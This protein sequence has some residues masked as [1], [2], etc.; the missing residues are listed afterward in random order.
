MTTKTK[1]LAVAGTVIAKTTQTLMGEVIDTGYHD[2]LTLHFEYNKGDETGLIIQV[3]TALDGDLTD[4]AQWQ[5]WTAAAGA[6]TATVN[7]ITPTDATPHYITFDVR[8]IAFMKF[9]Q[10]GSNNDG[11]PTGTYEASYTL[12]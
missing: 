12:K 10:G 9:T 3:H 6:K 11:T 5:D 4:V 7:T 1:V 8:G 2:F